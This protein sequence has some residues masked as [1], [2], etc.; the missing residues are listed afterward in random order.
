[1]GKLPV[2][3]AIVDLRRPRKDAATVLAYATGGGE[4]NRGRMSPQDFLKVLKA[5]TENGGPCPH[6]YQPPYLEAAKEHGVK[7][8]ASGRGKSMPLEWNEGQLGKW[9]EDDVLLDPRL[10]HNRDLRKRVAENALVVIDGLGTFVLGINGVNP[11]TTGAYAAIVDAL[12]AALFS[13][14]KGISNIVGRFNDEAFIDVTEDGGF[15]VWN[16]FQA[17]T[18][19]YLV[20]D[21]KRLSHA[22][23]AKLVGNSVDGVTFEKLD[24]VITRR[25]PLASVCDAVKSVMNADS[26]KDSEGLTAWNRFGYEND[27]DAYKAILVNVGTLCRFH[28]KVLNCFGLRNVQTGIPIFKAWDGTSVDDLSECV[29][30]SIGARLPVE[31]AENKWKAKARLTPPAPPA[32]PKKRGRK[33]K[34]VVAV[35]TETTEAPPVADTSEVAPVADVPQVT[36]SEEALTAAAV[37]ASEQ[38]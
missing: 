11:Q 16:P 20:K 13:N 33:P 8:A 37:E 23:V 18:W 30:M 1:M 9:G 28:P 10:H 15:I 38:G 12:K 24:E 34:N 7:I 6:I 4:V 2:K 31:A 26:T 29:C 25:I 27:G 17:L 22:S 21:G 5:F 3:H 32:E 19:G 36:M 14:V 35:V